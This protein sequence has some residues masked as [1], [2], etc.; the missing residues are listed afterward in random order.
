V[1]KGRDQEKRRYVSM[2][3]ER[4][5]ERRERERK[6]GKTRKKQCAVDECGA[7]VKKAN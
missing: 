2:R 6:R 7:K 5:R 3:S 1:E 4:A